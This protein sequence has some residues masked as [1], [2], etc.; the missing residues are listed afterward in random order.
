MCY[1]I[2]MT[3]VT[4][5]KSESEF[6]TRSRF[7]FHASMHIVMQL[8]DAEVI[9]CHSPDLGGSDRSVARPTAPSSVQDGVH[10]GRARVCNERHQWNKGAHG[11]LVVPTMMPTVGRAVTERIVGQTT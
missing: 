3:H 7:L 8:V 2:G 1:A 11:F 6:Y 5:P 10:R 4:H 9:C